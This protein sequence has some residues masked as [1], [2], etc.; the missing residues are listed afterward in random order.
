MPRC[1]RNWEDTA[2]RAFAFRAALTFFARGG[3]F[4]RTSFRL[5]GRFTRRFLTATRP[6]IR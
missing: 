6:P 3:L 5:R 4:A 2:R 1:D